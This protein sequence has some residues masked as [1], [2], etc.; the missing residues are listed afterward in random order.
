MT[1]KDYIMVA[2]VILRHFNSNLAYNNSDANL[3]LG[4]LVKELADKFA[5]ENPKFNRGKFL[6]LCDYNE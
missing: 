4:N 5:T 3:L 1:K 2:G 6:F